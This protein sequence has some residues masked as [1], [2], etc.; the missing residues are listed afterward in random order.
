VLLHIFYIYR[1]HVQDE[2]EDENGLRV[3]HWERQRWWYKLAHVSRQWRYLILASGS[4]L[5]LHLLCTYGVPVADMLSHSPSLPLTVYYMASDRTMTAAEDEE[6]AL[7]ALSHCDRVHHIAL[8]MPAPK[9]GK[10]I[11]AMDGSFPI[12][13]RLFVMSQPEEETNLTLPQT[14]QAPNLR[15]LSLGCIAVPIRSPLLTSIAGLV[16]LWLGGIPQSAYFPPSYLLTRLSLM[17]QLESLGIIFRSPLPNRD[18]VRQLMNT[19]NM[20]HVTLPNL[21]FISFRGVSA[22]LEGLLAQISAPLLFTLE[23]F[24]FNQLTF[25]IPQLLQFMQTSENLTFN[26]IELA[27]DRDFVDL[28]GDPHRRGW[29]LPLRLRIMCRHLDWQVASAAPILTT[30][31]PVLSV[32]EK[33]T[34]SNAKQ[35][36]SPGWHEVDR[37]QWRDLL[38]PFTNVKVLHLENELVGGLSHSLPSRDGEMPMEILPNLE[39]LT[40][41]GGDIGGAFTVFI[42]ERK[43]AGRLV[44]LES[45]L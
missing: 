28:K 43:A 36:R 38:R 14:F 7:L 34:L 6:G 39:E 10:F 9:L 29:E 41:S 37:T 19:P 45:C 20:T 26:A 44:R 32:V 25:T 17:P 16:E 2:Y 15:R 30:L 42:N 23:V 40:F 1:L 8:W 24:F 4:V 33:V 3:V 31:S 13:E 22:Y 11:P 21:R 12:L 18:V 35:G 5:D 27:F